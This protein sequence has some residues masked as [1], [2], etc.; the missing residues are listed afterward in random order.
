VIGC[1]LTVWRAKSQSLKAMNKEMF[2]RSKTEVLD[3]I[4]KL[5]GSDANRTL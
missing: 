2:E 4:R 5:I 1:V 3:V